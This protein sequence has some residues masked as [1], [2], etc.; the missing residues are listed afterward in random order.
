MIRVFIPNLH[1]TDAYLSH[2]P[3]L[4]RPEG[5]APPSAPSDSTRGRSR[6]TERSTLRRLM[7]PNFWN[8]IRSFG[9][10]AKD[11]ALTRSLVWLDS[12]DQAQ[13]FWDGR[14]MKRDVDGWPLPRSLM[15]P[16][17]S[18]VAFNTDTF[19]SQLH[20]YSS[21]PVSV[22]LHLFLSFINPTW[23]L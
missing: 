19:T 7:I 5:E 22:L 10:S 14:K 16:S 20:L 21:F 9:W 12:P 15:A 3:Y 8:V 6:L 23:L 1:W 18:L 17:L 4:L 2:H 11:E 13:W